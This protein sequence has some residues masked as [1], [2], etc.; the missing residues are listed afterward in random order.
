MWC[1]QAANKRKKKCLEIIYQACMQVCQVCL[2]KTH[3]DRVDFFFLNR[4]RQTAQVTVSCFLKKKKKVLRFSTIDDDRT[5]LPHFFCRIQPAFPGPTLPET[6]RKKKLVGLLLRQGASPA[7][8]A[9]ASIGARSDPSALLDSAN[10]KAFEP[11]P[12]MPDFALH[13]V[14]RN[15]QL[16]PDTIDKSTAAIRAHVR[17]PRQHPVE[18]HLARLC[19]SDYTRGALHALCWYLVAVS[20][21]Q[22]SHEAALG[23]DKSSTPP[24]VV[25]R[26]AGMEHREATAAIL[27]NDSNNNSSGGGGGGGSQAKQRLAAIAEPGG[28]GRGGGGTLAESMTDRLA[29][30]FDRMK[31]TRS[32]PSTKK[33]SGVA[34]NRGSDDCHSN[35]D[36]DFNEGDDVEDRRREYSRSSAGSFARFSFGGGTAGHTQAVGNAE[37]STRDSRSTPSP[38]SPRKSMLAGFRLGSPRGMGSRDMSPPC[39]RRAAVKTG[40]WKLGHEIGKGSF[41]KVHIGLNEES[42]DLIAVKVLPLRDGDTAEPLYKEI[43]L[44]RQLTH[45]NI[46]SYLGAEVRANHT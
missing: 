37:R 13:E 10:P 8:G 17:D 7:M 36:E 30:I 44:M 20:D 15:L 31:R 18:K 24:G 28:R 41:G 5:I 6:A 35:N 4:Y 42:G 12:P 29:T 23:G 45:P 9:T 3:R 21:L 22:A 14:L 39:P 26:S 16:S 32:M 25:S 33:Q 34:W 43:D 1:V 2:H 11:L 40:H 46:V 38:G 27:E 19:T